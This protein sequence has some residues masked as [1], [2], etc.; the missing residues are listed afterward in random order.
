MIPRPDASEHLPYY[1]KYVALVPDGDLI[2][3][4]RAQLDETLALVRGLPEAQGGHRYAPGKWSIRE[5][6]GHVID[7][8]RV[9]A[10]RALRIA[11]G[12]ATPMEGFDE[13]AYA[14]ASDADGRTLADLAEELQHVRLGNIAFFR[15]LSGEALARRGTANGAEVTVRA[16]AWILAG[17]ELHHRGLLHERYL[18]DAP[19]ASA[20]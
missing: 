7:T 11:R 1:G 19:A 15:A 4:L 3:M 18:A 5:V 20:V 12:D 14:A 9:F 13:N 8:E 10:Y 17:H 16:L 2:A 6:L